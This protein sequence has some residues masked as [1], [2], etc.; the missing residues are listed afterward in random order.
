MSPTS[1]AQVHKYF[2]PLSFFAW[3]K[4]YPELLFEVRTGVK[5][6]DIEQLKLILL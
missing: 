5:L 2:G 6:S 1:P 3:P 4:Y